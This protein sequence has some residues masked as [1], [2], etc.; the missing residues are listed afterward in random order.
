MA[1]GFSGRQTCLSTL[2][3][4]YPLIEV[5]REDSISVPKGGESLRAKKVVVAGGIA[6]FARIPKPFANLPPCLVS[7]TSQHNDLSKF[8]HKEVLVIGAGQSA[9]ESAVL[10]DEAG[11]RVQVLIQ[12]A[13][14]A[15]VG[16]KAPLDAR[17]SRR[18]DVVWAG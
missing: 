12:R 17:K 4:C 1:A 7:H 15:L 11:A 10:L 6:P 16:G 5:P 3:L 8:R 13:G 9:L 14:D 18:P 2:A